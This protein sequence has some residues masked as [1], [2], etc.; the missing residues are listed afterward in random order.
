ME[1]DFANH[2]FVLFVM[3]HCAQAMLMINLPQKW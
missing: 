1:A 3:S 2:M